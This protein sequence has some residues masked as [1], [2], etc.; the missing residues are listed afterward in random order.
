ML[1][2]AGVSG[3]TSVAF[4]V[5]GAVIGSAGLSGAVSI[6]TGALG[7]LVANSTVFMYSMFGSAFGT[8]IVATNNNGTVSGGVDESAITTC[9]ALGS[10]TKTCIYGTTGRAM[11][12]GGACGST[13]GVAR[14][15]NTTTGPQWVEEHAATVHASIVDA[16][17]TTRIASGSNG[18]SLPQSTINV[19]SASQL[20]SAPTVQIVSSNGV[21]TV[22]CG[23]KGPTTLTSCTGGTGTLATGNTVEDDSVRPLNLPA[24]GRALSIAADASDLSRI[25]IQIG[26]QSSDQSCF[27]GLCDS[28][29]DVNGDPMLQGTYYL[30]AIVWNT[31]TPS[32][33]LFGSCH[34]YGGVDF[35]SLCGENKENEDEQ[36]WGDNNTTVVSGSNKAYILARTCGTATCPNG[37]SSASTFFDST[38]V[39]TTP[40]VIVIKIDTENTSS[41]CTTPDDKATAVTCAAGLHNT[42]TEYI[43]KSTTAAASEGPDIIERWSNSHRINAIECSGTHGFVIEGICGATVYDDALNCRL[44]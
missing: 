30:R 44:P 33:G 1:G 20:S 24:Q 32:T 11:N 19:V 17:G 10:Q 35:S 15:S 42:I 29:A 41:A 18:A 4:D 34:L 8:A 21:Q 13:F 14:G 31:S 37:A 3:A 22:T 25:A 38:I 2:S 27:Y 40:H 23:G 9:G 43:D 26:T 6:V 5:A 16:Y 36:I 12:K 39:N 28:T 7:T